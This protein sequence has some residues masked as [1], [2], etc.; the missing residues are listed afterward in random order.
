MRSDIHNRPSPIQDDLKDSN[1]TCRRLVNDAEVSKGTLALIL[2]ERYSS[3]IRIQLL[4]DTAL[5][6]ENQVHAKG[7]VLSNKRGDGLYHV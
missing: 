3:M 7:E 1:Y 2:Q 5:P 4:I 6:R